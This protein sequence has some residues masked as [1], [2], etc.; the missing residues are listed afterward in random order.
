MLA[1]NDELLTF[2]A[3]ALASLLKRLGGRQ[4]VATPPRLGSVE[5]NHLID[6][7]HQVTKSQPTGRNHTLHLHSPGLGFH[8]AIAKVITA[9]ASEF[10]NLEGQ[11]VLIAVAN[12]QGINAG[13]VGRK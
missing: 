13:F 2:H 8:A 4:S 10:D 5:E 1:L 6:L 7:I 3:S 11:V 9:I 12:D